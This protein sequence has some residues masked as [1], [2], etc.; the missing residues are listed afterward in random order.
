MPLGR[1]R[2]Q[3]SREVGAS[4]KALEARQRQRG[5]SIALAAKKH[6]ANQKILGRRTKK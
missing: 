2:T 4:K 1:T 5:R 6:S 3:R